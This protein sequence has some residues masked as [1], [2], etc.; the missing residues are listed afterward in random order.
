MI[1]GVTAV[2]SFFVLATPIAMNM[3]TT[4]YREIYAA[5]RSSDSVFS[6]LVS[7]SRHFGI[8]FSVASVTGLLLLSAK[9]GKGHTA[10][11]LAIQFAITFLLFTRTQN[12]A[13]H[14][15]YWASVTIFV[16]TASFLQEAC[17]QL[18]TRLLKLAFVGVLIVACLS[19]FLSAF[20]EGVSNFF[21]PVS[22]A[23][24]QGR[25]YPLKRN[26]F[27]QVHSLLQTLNTLTRDSDS[28]IYILA[29]SGA[30]NGSIVRSGCH[31][32][33]PGLADLEQK[34]LV[35][36]DVDKRDGFP[37]QFF[38]ARYVVVTHPVG[39]HLAPEHQ[40][41][42]GL[43]AEELL[44]GEGLGQA[45]DRLPFAFTLEDASI[46]YIY[47]KTTDLKADA[48]KNISDTFVGLYPEYKGKFEITSE[49]I[50]V[51]SGS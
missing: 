19:N 22:F 43:L 41:V 37:F 25:F 29:S 17:A 23:F 35:T 8:L 26:D 3:L 33:E 28:K 34:L 42:I 11:F 9:D 13:A 10:L 7:L 16:L 48:L 44:N 47:E 21:S 38:Q 27:D 12:I 5:Y 1:V 20:H 46:A 40:R 4:N 39:Y 51:L 30:L 32:F 45:Y 50:R 49:M 31:T 18:K 15:Y 36:N 6:H 24:S 2:L 14:H